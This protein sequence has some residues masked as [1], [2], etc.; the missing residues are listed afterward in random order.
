MR[1]PLCI[2]PSRLIRT[3]GLLSLSLLLASTFT[4]VVA[5]SAWG[6]YGDVGYG[7][8]ITNFSGNGAAGAE[9]PNTALA[10]P[11][12]SKCSKTISA[13]VYVTN[14]RFP[15]LGVGLLT[16]GT[17]GGSYGSK[18]DKQDDAK[19]SFMAFSGAISAKY[20]FLSKS[21][22]QGFFTSGQLGLGQVARRVTAADGA[23]TSYTSSLAPT[24]GLGVGYAYPL[25]KFGKAISGSANFD[26]SS[27]RGDPAGTGFNQTLTMTQ[28]SLLFCYTF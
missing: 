24:A 23:A 1:T 25:T 18:K 12:E 13:A 11:N 6:I 7:I 10:L 28:V 16:K 15:G 27:H 3:F 4:S 9:Y 17:F 20:F 26:T 5:Q 2:L 22:N 8:T 19:T 21:F 14:S